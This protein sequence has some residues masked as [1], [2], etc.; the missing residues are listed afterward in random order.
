MHYSEE[1]PLDSKP[2]KIIMEDH[3]PE[4]QPEQKE[5]TRPIELL[6]RSSL[7]LDGFEMELCSTQLS[8]GHLTDIIYNVYMILREQ[9]KGIKKKMIGVD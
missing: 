2:P 5:S 1:D 9:N 6:E 4:D 8:A 3:E 7:K